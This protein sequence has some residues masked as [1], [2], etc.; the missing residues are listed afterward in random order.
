M[1]E[2]EAERIHK[3][4]VIVEGHRDIFEMFHL[5]KQGTQYPV[6]NVTVPRL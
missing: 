6:L 2:P 4:A 5:A 1:I 3:K